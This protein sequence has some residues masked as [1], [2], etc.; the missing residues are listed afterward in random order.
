M[1]YDLRC[2]N[3]NV[4][5]AIYIKSEVTKL[6]SVSIVNNSSNY[7]VAIPI[8]QTNIPD[9]VI[10]LSDGLLIA[11]NSTEAYVPKFVKLS[12]GTISSNM[13]AAKLNG[14]NIKIVVL[15]LA[16]DDSID[17]C[18]GAINVTG[19]DEG[20]LKPKRRGRPPRVINTGTEKEP[21][22]TFIPKV[23]QSNKLL[24]EANLAFDNLP[25]FKIDPSDKSDDDRIQNYN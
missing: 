25:A 4:D 15:D 6:S 8:L 10:F 18:Q 17:E 20:A 19:D 22:A 2:I 11:P 1:S 14:V 24:D 23:I 16:L 13:I 3:Y 9:N 7:C 5:S 12:C 21:S